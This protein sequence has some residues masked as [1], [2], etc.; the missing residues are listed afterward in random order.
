[1]RSIV[2]CYLA[3]DYARQQAAHHTEGH[4]PPVRE[5]QQIEHAER[6]DSDENGAEIG[7]NAQRAQQVF[8]RSPFLGT[9]H[10]NSYDREYYAKGS[11]EHRRHDGPHLH[12]HPVG[13]EGRCPQ[14]HRG[15]DAAAIRLVQVCAH[16]GYVAHIVTHVVGDGGRIAGV[17]LRNVLLYLSHDICADIGR[18][19]IDTAAH[20][21][22]QSLGRSTHP[23]GEHGGSN[24]HKCLSI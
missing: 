4:L 17:V 7:T 18:L 16:A 11:D 5:A 24:H 3:D 15:Q 21:G 14:R 22:E 13:K 23:E 8:Q 19:G 2:L 20:T 12:I 6:Q 9:D 10:I 1:M